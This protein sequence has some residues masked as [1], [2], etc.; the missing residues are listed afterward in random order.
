MDKTLCTTL[1]MLACC[2]VS[3]LSAQSEVYV[4]PALDDWQQWVLEGEEHRSCPFFGNRL[5]GEVV[6]H[7]CAWPQRLNLVVV[8]AGARF[9]QRWRVDTDSW[10]PVPGDAL[11]WPQDV[12][13]DGRSARVVSRNNIPHVFLTP[14]TYRIAGFL[15]WAS[16]PASIRLPMAT[17]L[18]DLTID[19]EA[20]RYPRREGDALFLGESPQQG[21]EQEKLDIQVYRAIT[22][23]V[24]I[25]AMTVVSLDI[26]GP[27]RE[28]T[29]GRV[30]LAGFVPM[31]LTSPLPAR[32]GPE[33]ELIVQARPGS[34]ELMISA[35]AT[36]ATDAIALSAQEGNW[37]KE[38]VWSYRS[39]DRLRVTSVQGGEPVDPVQAGVPSDWIQLPSFRMTPGD[40]LVI[41]ERTR[42]LSEED[43]NQL[44]L[45][46]D[47]W[48]DFNRGGLTAR[49]QI[50]GT[51][52]QGWRL[53]MALPYRMQSALE[54]EENLL[55]TDASHAGGTGVELRSPE[56]GL[57]T[58]SRVIWVSGPIPVTGYQE[59]FNA[60]TTQLHL[61]PGH[62]L[63]RAGGADRADAWLDRWRLLDLFLVLIVAVAVG[64]LLNP[65]LGAVT[66]VMLVLTYHEGSAPVWSWLNL[67]VAMALAAVAPEG[68][69]RRWANGYRN[70]SFGLLVIVAVPFLAAQARLA[71][72]PQLEQ[73]SI[74]MLGAG[75]G[76]SLGQDH[77][78]QMERA[79][80]AD[81]PASAPAETAALEEIAVTGSKPYKAYS[82]YEPSALVQTGPG[83]PDW[84]WHR[85]RLSW[86]GPVT[87][88]QE[89]EIL[90]LPPWAVSLWRTLGIFL[91]LIVI[92]ALSRA[93]FS[94][95]R[96][97]PFQKPSIQASIV[98][99]LI[100]SGFVQPQTSHAQEPIPDAAMLEELKHRL[101][102]PQECSPQCGELARAVVEADES[103]LTIR[104]WMHALANVALPLPGDLKAWQP[105]RVEVEGVATSALYRDRAGIL[106]LNLAAGTHQVMLRGPLPPVDSLTVAFPQP[107][108]FVQVDAEGWDYSGV[109]ENRL[110]SG[111][112]ELI[113]RATESEDDRET[114]R[115][116]RFEPFV[117]VVRR[118]Q[119][120]IDWFVSTEVH[121]LAPVAGAF[122][123]EIPVLEG[124]SVISPGVEVRDRRVLV[125]MHAGLNTFSWRSTL[126][127]G[128]RLEL[129]SN[130]GKSWSEVWHV[131]ATPIWHVEHDGIPAVAPEDPESYIWVPEFYPQPGETLVLDITRPAGAEGRTLAIDEVSVVTRIG[132]RSTESDL[133][134]S[135]RSTRGGQHPINLPEDA[136]VLEVKSDGRAIPLRPEDGALPLPLAPGAHHYEISWRSE[137]EVENVQRSALVDMGAGSSNI[138]LALSVPNDRWIL[139]AS[140]PRLGPAILYWP[141]LLAFVVV[142][143][144]LAR[145]RRTPLQSWD[146]L[147]LGL[148]LSTFA[149]PV[150]LLVIVWLF[151]MDWRQE[152]DLGD[153]PWR[154]NLTQLGLGVLSVSA[155]LALVGAIPTGLLGS[156]DMQISG[157][158]S[159]RNNLNWFQDQA[160]TS[161]PQGRVFSISIWYYKAA[162]LLWALWL[163]FALLKWLPWA[164]RC[165]SAQGFWKGR[166]IT[167][168]SAKGR[169]AE[170]T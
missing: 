73:S 150:L 113:R 67:L 117:R 145:T 100:V 85:H 132:K 97:L 133:S 118:L 43:G 99:A 17:G 95:P 110:L 76:D 89:V 151:V 35:R 46:R 144:L 37:P 153:S 9:D 143:F 147:L 5:P 80:V 75:Y 26:S 2:W 40:S 74:S 136:Q 79:R 86:S 23:G 19:G 68:R 66:L 70:L 15:R 146:W 52:R 156:P 101:T 69:F 1:V 33:G 59:S 125:A 34:W 38:E 126:P 170:K 48:L 51:M 163:S 128:S 116:E 134:F 112:I 58:V 44:T 6:N 140:G 88:E 90:V 111:S 77:T 166:L 13:V 29:L 12:T 149:W 36:A 91:I 54:G 39:R 114:V 104:L 94:F 162:I 139:Y 159:F 65:Y 108:R 45:N 93:A 129:T 131:E 105:A 148:G 25:T 21:E 84:T 157:Q 135:Y 22:D 167:R 10:I 11:H 62:R 161:L 24:P 53:D 41:T 122:T 138:R 8:G 60:V 168:K 83:V 72:F 28:E 119:F 3:Q 137:R 121:R 169:K 7:I 102:Q 63:L 57:Q 32:I 109:N 78:F 81:L 4:P 98:A 71:L 30:M 18:V 96:R 16:R 154:F 61:P 103:E 56:L 124:E 155:V 141:E 165:Y 31:D 42:G 27:G 49:D 107:P 158:Q 152:A 160:Q 120:G 14:G 106:W 130:K 92:G 164:W 115:S 55:V 123:L 87:V 64:K 142:A 127:Q 20:V 50:S 47:M 82:R